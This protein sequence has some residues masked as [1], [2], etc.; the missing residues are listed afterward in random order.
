MRRF[1]PVGGILLLLIALLAGCGDQPQP[2]Q[3]QKKPG[4][5]SAGATPTTTPA[6]DS[7]AALRQKPLHLPTLAPGVACPVDVEKLISPD[8]GLAPGDG[9]LYPIGPWKQGI[10]N[11]AGVAVSSD[12]WYYLKVL[13]A[14]Q[15]DFQGQALI[16]GHQLDGPNELRFSEGTNS[17]AEPEL[18]FV[19]DGSTA[20]SSGWNSTA[21]YTRVRSPG[22]YAY[23]VDSAN[24]SEVII[25]QAV[26]P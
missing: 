25:F 5:T 21:T 14:A 6:A 10:Y 16:R 26:G 4:T 1:L 2:S 3:T 8:L 20:N 17:P 23:Q 13:W 15:P 11:Y 24:S 22:C 9:P 12:G 18:H 19:A 7:W